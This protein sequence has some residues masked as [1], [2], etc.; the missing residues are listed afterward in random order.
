M[1]KNYQKKLKIFVVFGILFLGFCL[2]FYKVDSI[3]PGITMDESSIGYNAYSV[4]KTGKDEYGKPFPIMFRS[5][6][7]YK[8]PVYFYLTVPFIKI[9]DLNVLSLRLPSVIAGTL[10]GFLIYFIVLQ[11]FGKKRW[12][13]ACLSLIIY[14]FSPW[15]V[16]FSRVA[17]ESNLAL[18]FLLL[19]VYLQLISLEKGK[20]GLFLISS[21]IYCL[22]VYSYHTERFLSPIFLAGVTFFFYNRKREQEKIPKKIVILAFLIFFLISFP[23]YYFLKQAAGNTRIKSTSIIKQEEIKEALHYPPQILFLIE[24]QLSLYV[25]YFS[26]RNLFFDPDPVK[27]R[28]APEISTFYFW[29]VIPYLFGLYF[30]T[31]EKERKVKNFLI[32][33]L[34][35]SPIPAA[36]TG[37]PFASLRALPLIFPLSIIIGLGLEKLFCSRKILKITIPLF[38]LLLIFSLIFLSRSIFTLLFYE[39]YLDWNFGYSQLVEKINQFSDF[40]VLFDDPVGDNYPEFLFFLR[41]PPIKFQQEQNLI[42][43]KKYYQISEWKNTFN[44]GRIEVRA[45]NWK[46]D[47]YEKKLIIA[48]PIAISEGQAKEHFLTKTFAIIA[49]DGKIVFNGYITNPELKRQD[50]E[51]KRG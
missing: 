6:A 15:S 44:F 24:R 20:W 48:S 27:T 47:I 4:L 39:K 37:D 14:I 18:F 42:D 33:L 50:E 30:L 21:L 38:S 8:L 43:L 11:L 40:K 10:S 51:K 7:D 25:A 31:L 32:F 16:H 35:T 19:A 2:R 26:P 34:L 17:F 36:F 45:I 41:Y 13:L 12:R 28:S 22:A 1:K 46:K 29:M 3:P 5:F 23:Q 49:P 9:F